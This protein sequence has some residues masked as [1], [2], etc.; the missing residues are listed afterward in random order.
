[1]HLQYSSVSAQSNSMTL[2]NALFSLL[3]VARHFSF[4]LGPPKWMQG[5]SRLDHAQC[6]VAGPSAVKETR[7]THGAHTISGFS[8]SA[9]FG[10]FAGRPHG[11]SAVSA[12]HYCTANQY[13]PSCVA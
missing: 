1:M 9:S 7:W 3:L 10:G 2:Y 6:D 13:V 12:H 11:A 5:A 8:V 4:L